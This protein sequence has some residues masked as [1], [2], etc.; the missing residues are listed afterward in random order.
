MR[1]QELPV[2]MDTLKTFAGFIGCPF[3]GRQAIRK[4]CG[5]SFREFWEATYAQTEEPEDGWPEEIQ[6]GLEA[7][8]TSFTTKGET[9]QEVSRSPTPT[10][11]TI[12]APLPPSCS[13]FKLVPALWTPD[14]CSDSASPYMGWTM[15]TRPTTPTTPTA[16]SRSFF[17]S[18]PQAGVATPP[19]PQKPPV[20]FDFLTQ[21][22]VGLPSSPVRVPGSVQS[23]GH[24]QTPRRTPR[25]VGRG[26]SPGKRRKVEEDKENEQP[27]VWM[28]P[29]KSGRIRSV[30]ERLEEVCGGG[31]SVK[32]LG[33]R[34]SFNREEE[35][36]G[37]RPSPLKK[38]RK[39][40]EEE[41]S[42]DEGNDVEKSEE[43]DVFGTK[44]AVPTF[45]TFYTGPTRKPFQVPLPP[46]LAPLKVERQEKEQQLPS[47]KRKRV[48]MDAVVLPT[49]RE[50]YGSSMIRS[51]GL[52]SSVSFD[53]GL[54]MR[55]PRSV[56]VREGVARGTRSAT[57]HRRAD[58][59][60]S[61]SAMERK[62]ENRRR[63]SAL[64]GNVQTSSSDGFEDGSDPIELRPGLRRVASQPAS[65]SSDDDPHLGQVTPHH[66]ISPH[67]K[68]SARGL[69]RF[70]GEG[71][72]ASDDSVPSPSKD[73]VE[74]KL[75]RE[76]K[77]L[78]F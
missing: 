36:A 73:I 55:T 18:L 53:S 17:P 7:V 59:L 11:S 20:S 12:P 30:A 34:R 50:V 25:S 29:A 9:V 10:L 40:E 41:E 21:L 28:S 51:G 58:A 77:P 45:V 67:L 22:P 37:G 27:D 43:D 54:K 46:A 69:G 13:A 6:T 8:F 52:R 57:K 24:P 44:L 74:R 71:E 3:N 26:G 78:V 19:R 2:T 49:L 75:K 76:L 63:A 33:K 62:A 72:P 47:K 23:S 65:S 56:S 16:G 4:M 61:C 31:G 39:E 38:G 48:I 35:D 5:E 66:L 15:P 64:S 32:T 60:A 68:K 70:Y 42:E 1:I 14:V